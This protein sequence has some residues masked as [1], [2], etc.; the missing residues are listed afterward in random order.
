MTRSHR[1]AHRLIWPIL[2]IAVVLGVT[3]ALVLRS[4]P[5]PLPSME[6]TP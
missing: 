4:P 3:M 6:T 2:A 1:L 5:E